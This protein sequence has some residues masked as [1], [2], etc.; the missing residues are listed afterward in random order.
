MEPLKYTPL[1]HRMLAAIN[2]GKVD[3]SRWGSRT[4][5][6]RDDA[7]TYGRMEQA[8]SAIIH[9][10][11]ALIVGLMGGPVALTPEGSALLSEW[12]A[13]HGNPLE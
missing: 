5:D 8:V 9:T 3:R 6:I 12:N 2:D 7:S 1:R 10:D 13:K 4:W 11:L